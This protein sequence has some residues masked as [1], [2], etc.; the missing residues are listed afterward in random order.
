M[1]LTYI[2]KSLG[3]IMLDILE[4]QIGPE[5]LALSMEEIKKKKSCNLYD[6]T[7]ITKER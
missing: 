5:L 7:K 6:E 2:K 4:K 3:T 1:I